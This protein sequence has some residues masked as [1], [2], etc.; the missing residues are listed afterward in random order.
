MSEKRKP[1]FVYVGAAKAGS[2][3][4]YEVMRE[5]PD[6]YV[7]DAKELFYFDRY[8]DKGEEWYLTHFDDAL[9]EQVV[10]ELSHDYFLDPECAHRIK[11][12]NPNIKIIVCLREG[13]DQAFSSYLY[14]KTI[15]QYFPR[16]RYEKGFTFREFA[17]EPH[18]I[19][20]SD[21]FHN[22]KPYYD[23]FP[24][25][26]IAVLF[27]DDLKADPADFAKQIFAFL[28]VDQSFVPSILHKKVN[29]AREP[30]IQWIADLAYKAGQLLRKKGNAALMGSIKRQPLF[31]KILYKQYNDKA[32]RPTIPAEDIPILKEIYHK[33]DAALSDLIGRELPAKWKD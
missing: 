9:P 29:V 4:I 12:C 2:S 28:G 16:K 5:H 15:Y 23:L 21:Y 30:R 8:Y 1:D 26:N 33:D 3:W 14:D 18:A 24:R 6:I 25:E 10:G 19:H 22:L 27:Y 20:L 17:Q 32:S 31:E 13:I 7:S 11:E